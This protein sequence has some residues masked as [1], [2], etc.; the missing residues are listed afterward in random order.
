MITGSQAAVT[1]RTMYKKYHVA[2]ET[3]HLL[4][5]GP[6]TPY[7][8]YREGGDDFILVAWVPGDDAPA[9][10]QIEAYVLYGCA[11]HGGHGRGA[12]LH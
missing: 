4:D 8:L 12:M 3:Y 10:E 7:G 1:G 9:Q 2:G 5:E 11:L 6:N